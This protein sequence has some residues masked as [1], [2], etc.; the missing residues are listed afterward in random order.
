MVIPIQAGTIPLQSN[1][2]D[3]VDLE[4]KSLEPA[5][6]ISF[7]TPSATAMEKMDWI[8]NYFRHHN[9]HQIIKLFF[10]QWR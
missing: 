1:D 2:I 7:T 4:I 6:S 9:F 10:Q 5:T 8:R 3:V